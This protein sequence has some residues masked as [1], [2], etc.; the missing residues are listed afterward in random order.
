MNLDSLHFYFPGTMKEIVGV[1][2][3]RDC[4]D[5]V[6]EAQLQFA[7]GTYS[8]VF[9]VLGSDSKVSNVYRAYVRWSWKAPYR[10]RLFRVYAGPIF[11]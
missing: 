9:K 8:K 1:S 11:R 5:R 3:H 4:R 7:G 6:V 2:E 10:R